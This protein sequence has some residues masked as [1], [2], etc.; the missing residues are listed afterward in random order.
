MY[1]SNLKLWNFRKFT[2]EDG[3]IDLTHPHLEVPFTKGLNVLIG[4]NDSGKTVVID[5][6]KMITK[7]HSVEWI[8]LLDSDFS[9]GRSN[10]RIEVT[11]SDL[12]DDEAVP[13]P[14]KVIIDEG[15]SSVSL[16][17][18]L[19]AQK[20]DDRIL[21]YEV[22]ADNGVQTALNAREKEQLKA[23]YLRALRDADNELTAKRNSRISQILLGHELFAEGGSGKI[24]FE[25]IFLSANNSLSDWFNNT[26]GGDK[27]NKS[28]IKDVID[29]FIHAFIDDSFYSDISVSGSD[30]KSILEKISIGIVGV[31]NLGLGSM[32]R[33]FMASELLHLKNKDSCVKLCL[34]EELEAHL[35]P[36]AQMKVI[37]CLQNEN[38]VQFIMSTHSPNLASKI[39]LDSENTS[40]ILFKE[41]DVFPLTKGLTKLEGKDYKYLDHFLD[42]TKSNLFFAKGII[43]VEGWAEELILPV[44]ANNQ[45][46]NL[47]KYEIS[48]VNVG[49]TA[50]LHYA[51]I[52]MRTDSKIL[53]YPV[54]IVTDYDVRP[55]EDWTFD[56]TEEEEKKQKIE[57]IL[58]IGTNHNVDLCLATHW[59]LE[60]CL[61]ESEA[62]SEMFMKCCAKVHNGTD[63]FKRTEAGEWN[64][65]SFRNK[66][67]KKLIDRSL[68]KVEIASELCQLIKASTNPIQINNDDTAYYLIKAINCVCK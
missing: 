44:L 63:E 7:T 16:Q 3:I 54:A 9:K 4:E 14:E 52:L 65:D 22:K 6:I 32:N 68:E 46:K 53:K 27:S 17:L 33:L 43:I 67:A 59:T 62:L 25:D 42:V 12:S 39:K 13:F 23:T 58:D 30:I 61:F 19:E 60:W 11:F 24:E 2:N 36:Q 45:G 55:K 29:D 50:Y 10:L 64:K 18:V 38:T 1:L 66:L 51:R 40:I 28:Q 26:E 35:H 34:I 37:D 57:N 31:E 21:P 47:T 48:I 41:G 49:S 15:N 20:I 56:N 5:A 8:H